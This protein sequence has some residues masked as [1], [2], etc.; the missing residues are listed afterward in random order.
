MGKKYEIE[1]GWVERKEWKI[2]DR[3]R[4]GKYVY[5]P[6]KS[7]GGSGNDLE[8]SEMLLVENIKRGKKNCYYLGRFPGVPGINRKSL[9]CC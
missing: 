9:E 5:L 2:G 6:R 8:L 3:K 4:G 1:K 7:S